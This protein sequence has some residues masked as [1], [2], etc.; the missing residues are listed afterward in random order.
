[1]SKNV[2]IKDIASHTGLSV[3][4]VSKVINGHPDI[5]QKTQERVL[6]A[7]D[8][9]GYIP[10]IM[11]S[12]LRK[13]KANLIALL[14]SDISKPYFS[15]VI[16]GYEKVLLK[17]GY[18]TLIFSSVEDSERESNLIRQL[19][20]INLAGII[21][22]L[23]QNGAKNIELLENIGIPYVFSNRFVHVNEGYYVAADNKKAG[24]IATRHLLEVKPGNPVLYVNGP[25]DISPTEMRYL[26][27]CMA[28]DEVGIGRNEEWVFGNHYGLEDAF[29]TGLFI[30]KT[31]KPPYSIFCATDQIAIGVLRAL[32]DNQVN[33]PEDV[34]VIGVDD[35][36][37]AK[38][39]S[40]SL[41]TIS[42]PK[43]LIGEKSAEMLISLI[44]NEI[45]EQ[46]R[47]LLSPELVIRE[48]T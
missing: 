34:S 45:I 37:I 9:M 39:V 11:A 5:S 46:P 23:A 7:I 24:Y 8:E 14:L 6:G 38:Y 43:E 29:R 20:S 48:T 12:N 21:I 42:L 16:S 15:E 28:L 22:D 1:M 33:V 4:T 41:S 36:D 47:C 35:I 32:K 44:K 17:A 25:D 26:G 31:F 13:N 27:Y 3:T 19:S 2:T 10:N 30:A 40:P 18:Q